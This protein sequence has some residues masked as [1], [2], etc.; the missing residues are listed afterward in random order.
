M[1][2]SEYL[3]SMNQKFSGKCVRLYC[4]K[5]Q[6]VEG[7][8]LGIWRDGHLSYISYCHNKKTANICNLQ[9][10]KVGMIQ[11]L[12]EVAAEEK[13]LIYQYISSGTSI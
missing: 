7:I 3:K 5:D 9:L 6:Y 11:A 13:K 12:Q 8:Y 2:L 4:A 10:E 1:Q